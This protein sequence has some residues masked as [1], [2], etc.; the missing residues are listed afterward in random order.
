[1]NC[2][3]YKGL[4]IGLLSALLLSQYVTFICLLIDGAV[5]IVASHPIS[6]AD[7]TACRCG[8]FWRW[9]VSSPFPALG[10]Q[11][12]LWLPKDWQC[13]VNKNVFHVQ[14]AA[15][16]FSLLSS[17]RQWRMYMGGTFDAWGTF[18]SISLSLSIVF[19]GLRGNSR[20]NEIDVHL[21]GCWLDTA[22]W[23]K[24]SNLVIKSQKCLRTPMFMQAYTQA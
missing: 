3:E 17:A 14:I 20:R 4:E 18:V 6:Q 5:S 22:T 24:D 1:M 11:F 10:S 8:G 16:G 15:I 19:C 2:R 23:V 9:A 21:A 12:H 7:S 13:S